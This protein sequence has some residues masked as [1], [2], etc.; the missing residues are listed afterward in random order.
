MSS[1]DLLD[2]LFDFAFAGFDLAFALDA[3][4]FAMVIPFMCDVMYRLQPAL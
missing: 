4:F 1:D 2:R 3:F